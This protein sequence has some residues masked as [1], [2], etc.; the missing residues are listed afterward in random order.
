MFGNIV[1]A[2]IWLIVL[3]LIWW[4]VGF[5]PLPHPIGIVVMVLFVVLAII[6]V[7]SL[8]GMIPFGVPRP[9][10]GE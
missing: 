5:L 1:N 3:G 4:L 2:I 8:F 9:Y 10:K 7:L 6:I